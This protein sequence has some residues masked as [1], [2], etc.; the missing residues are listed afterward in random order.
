M[1]ICCDASIVNVY[2]QLYQLNP[3]SRA[4]REVPPTPKRSESVTCCN[5][6]IV[7]LMDVGITKSVE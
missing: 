1:N 4:K 3:G 2:D 5:N 6:Q 7:E